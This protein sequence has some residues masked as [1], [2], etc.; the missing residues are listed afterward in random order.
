MSVLQHILP[1]LALLP[2]AQ[3]ALS[4]AADPI[5]PDFAA[6]DFSTPRANPYL[7]M[8]LG[9]SV[10]VMAG[11]V[12]D[13]ETVPELAVRTIIGPGP[14]LMGVQT[15]TAVDETFLSGHLVERTLDYLAADSAG[16]IW[17]LGE[18]V[19]N[20][21]Y[22]ATGILTGTDNHSA[23]LAGVDG[24]LPGITM[25]A[26]LT[27]D[28]VLFQEHAPAQ[29]ALDYARIVETGLTIQTPDGSYSD[30]IKFYEASLSELDLR[31]YKYYATGVGMIR[32]EEDLDE[33]LAN[34]GVILEIQP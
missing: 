4:Q 27:V 6:A 26:D 29:E 18:D 8:T 22:D 5:L 2:L 1:V 30:V 11:S 14:V 28:V 32:A 9:Q 17:Y 34:P 25:P 31:E 13:G 12:A 21:V 19:E 23:W 24:A 7:P 15:T 20:F 33:T 16:N 10:T 3:P